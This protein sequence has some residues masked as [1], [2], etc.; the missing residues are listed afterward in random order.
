LWDS[1]HTEI[2]LEI[3]KIY[4]GDYPELSTKIPLVLRLQIFFHS[5]GAKSLM[6]EISS[7]H[8]SSDGFGS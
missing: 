6:R 2:R 3:K 1:S 8:L 4:G 5:N 7:L